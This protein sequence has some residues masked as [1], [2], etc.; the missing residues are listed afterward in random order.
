VGLGIAVRLLEESLNL[1][2]LFVPASRIEHIV[3]HRKIGDLWVI[4]P[5]QRLDSSASVGLS[6]LALASRFVDIPT[7]EERI[8]AID[9]RL[10]FLKAVLRNPSRAQNILLAAQWL[11]ENH[12]GSDELLGF[13]QM[14]VVAE[15]LLGDK[16]SSDLVGVTELLANR[17]AYLIADSAAERDLLI[18]DFRAIYTVRSAIVHSGKSRLN[19]Q[20]RRLLDRLR[21]ICARIILKEMQLL[22]V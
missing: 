17:C 21:Q 2:T 3:V 11:F 1:A 16:R 9:K 13:V 5:L 8:A 4:E 14:T 15:I 10:G 22:D 19:S 6:K 7:D 18:Q 20:E 12:S